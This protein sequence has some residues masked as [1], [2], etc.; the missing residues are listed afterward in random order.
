MDVTIPTS[1]KDINIDTYINLVPVLE[2]EQEPITRIINILCVL[3]GKKREEIREL[4][5][6]NYQSLIKK[7]S[8][9]FAEIPT[10]LKSKRIKIEGNYYE[11]KLQA[12]N[13]LF[14][15]YINAMETL[16]SKTENGVIQNLDKIL[17]TICRPVERRYGIWR[18][19]K[20][21]SKL[22]QETIKLFRFKMSIADAYPLC[23]FF[24]SHSKDL[25]ENI[26]TSLS[27]QAKKLKK[28]ANLSMIGGVGGV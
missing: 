15:E 27:L 1:W 18:E 21:T 24:C 11:F 19:R 28:E 7:M 20:M 17:A 14:G 26:K 2:T 8:F 25:M 23:V 22:L 9:L 3:T 5:L 16:N 6:D 12:E 10:N 4:Q 13:L